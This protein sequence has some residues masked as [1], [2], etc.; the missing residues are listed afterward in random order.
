MTD[1]QALILWYQ[2]VS[3]NDP[4]LANFAGAW[5]LLM[6]ARIGRGTRPSPHLFASTMVFAGQ[7]VGDEPTGA[8]LDS[9]V[10]A[11]VRAWRHGEAFGDWFTSA[12]TPR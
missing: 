1:F 3:Q 11:I 12:A 7:L 4:A 6:E 8:R 5:V 9:A 2:D 10:F